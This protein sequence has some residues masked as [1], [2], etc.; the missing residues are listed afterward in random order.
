M[1]RTERFFVPVVLSGFT[2][3]IYW[4]TTTFPPIAARFPKL[5]IASMFLLSFILL[6]QEWRT[7]NV[8]HQEMP[9]KE[10]IE[11]SGAAGLGLVSPKARQL[12]IITSLVMYIILLNY[13]GF[14]ITTFLFLLV[15]FLLL[16][17]RKKSTIL[18][19]TVCITFIIFL[20]FEKIFL[21]IFPEG[22]ILPAIF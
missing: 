14:L 13:L 20:V 8:A 22:V 3:L 10:T 5:L 1:S 2:G 17:Y 12:L 6:V 19:V 9:E 21:I 7:R 4:E 16:G 15:Q 18:T 11:P